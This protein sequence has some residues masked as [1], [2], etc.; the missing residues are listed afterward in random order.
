[1]AMSELNPLYNNGLFLL[2]GNNKFGIV[3]C[4]YLGV[5][6]YR[7]KKYCIRFFCLKTLFTFTNNVDPDEN[8]YICYISSGSSLFAKVFVLGFTEYRE[9]CI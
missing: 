5:S 2:V 7:L 8:Q 6:G 9:L 3:H 4:T 1:M